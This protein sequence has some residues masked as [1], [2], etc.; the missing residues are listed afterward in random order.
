MQCQCAPVNADVRRHMW[1]PSELARWCLGRRWITFSGDGDTLV[2]ASEF[3]RVRLD[4]K[5]QVVV[6]EGR[7]AARWGQLEG[8]S[9]ERRQ[10]DDDG[11]VHWLLS[12][13]TSSSSAVVLGKVTDEYDASH[14]AA[15]VAT[16]CNIEVEARR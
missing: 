7:V 5:G 11:P 6:A 15:R 8:V 12:L 9:L 16:F 1:S 10:T 4:R 3:R 14:I 13:R 2:L